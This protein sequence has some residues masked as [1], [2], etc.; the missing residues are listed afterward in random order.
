MPPRKKPTSTT[1]KKAQ[2]KLKRAIKR[3][4]VAAPPPQTKQNKNRRRAHGPPVSQTVESSRKLQS[5]FISLPPEFLENTKVLASQLPL[6]RPIPHNSLLLPVYDAEYALACPRRPKWKFTM[7]KLEVEKNEEGV[8]RKWLFQTDDLVE[9]WQKQPPEPAAM[10]RSTTVFERNI[11]V[12][13]QLWRVTEISDI[14]LVLL[15]SR[16]PLLHFPPSLQ[17]YLE[18]R[19]VILVLTKVDIAGPERAEAWTRYFATNHP[20]YKV[21]QVESYIEKEVTSLSQ[22][23]RQHRPHIPE[24]F[25]TRLIQAIREEHAA[26]LEPPEKVKANP[27][28]LEHWKPKVKREIDWDRLLTA[29]GEKVGSIVGGPAAPQPD[30]EASEEEQEPQFLTIGLIGQPNVGKSSL[31]NALFGTS[32]VRASK[33]PGKTKHFQTLFFTPDVRVVDCPGLVMPNFVPLEMQVLAGILPIS[34]RRCFHAFLLHILIYVV[35]V[36][37]VPFCTYHAAQLLPLERI[38]RIAKPEPVE[39]VDKRTWREG[40]RPPAED[41][42]ERPWSAMDVLIGYAEAKGWMTAKG[43]RPDVHRAGNAILRA[44]AE[45]RITWAFWPPDAAETAHASTEGAGIWIQS[46]DGAMSSEEESEDEPEE[47]EAE[48]QVQSSDEASEPQSADE[49]EDEEEE[50]APLKTGIGRFGALLDEDSKSDAESE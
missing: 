14:L 19:S 32:K 31:L 40:E 48:N 7:S 38:L 35:V 37:A 18:N 30:A 33:T 29:E 23:R 44:L 16:A 43:G 8:F 22:G 34:R 5:A 17:D 25:R 50:A 6:S 28:R 27:A 10:P 45:G 39:V 9:K 2:T 49:E 20:S 13:R 12:W 15:D 3:G 42:R 41:L 26:L 21:V 4:D 36:A 1:A 24:T 46:E 47:D 11:E